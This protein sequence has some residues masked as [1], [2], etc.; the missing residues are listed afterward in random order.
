[1]VSSMS[2]MAVLENR[3]ANANMI[4]EA[5]IDIANECGETMAWA[6]PGNSEINLCDKRNES[7]KK[8]NVGE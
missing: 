6:R 8:Y 7:I 2:G 1:M 3:N 4:H 5:H